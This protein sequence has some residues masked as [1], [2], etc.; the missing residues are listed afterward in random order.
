[1]IVFLYVHFSGVNCESD[2]DEC[3]SFRPCQ[4]DGQCVDL[5]NAFRCICQPGFTGK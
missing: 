4:N 2:L 3:L 1:M 5:V